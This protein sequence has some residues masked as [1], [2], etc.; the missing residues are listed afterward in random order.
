[1]KTNALTDSEIIAKHSPDARARARMELDIV[2]KLID[3]ARDAGYQM[4]IS[5]YEEDGETDYDFKTAAFNLDDARVFVY[6]NDGEKLGWVRLVFGNSGYD[7]V[8]DFTTNLEDFLGP[9]TDLA[10]S[11]G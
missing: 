3:T 11:L 9:V 8:S 7:L 6:D 1:M 4:K 10:D 2:N 5:E